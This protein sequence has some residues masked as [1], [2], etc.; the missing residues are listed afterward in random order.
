MMG[1]LNDKMKPKFIHIPIDNYIIDAAKKTGKISKLLDIE[2]L[3][4]EPTFTEKWSQLHCYNK[5]LEYQKNIRKE[6]MIR[7]CMPIDWESE[8]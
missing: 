1:L 3:G 6:L 4:I 7:N 8:A 5:Y 2:G